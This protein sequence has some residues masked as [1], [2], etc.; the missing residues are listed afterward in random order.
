[1]NVEPSNGSAATEVMIHTADAARVENDGAAIPSSAFAVFPSDIQIQLL[2]SPAQT[3]AN[4][5][6]NIPA[7]VMAAP[8]I[9]MAI[10]MCD[11]ALSDPTSGNDIIRCINAATHTTT[12]PAREMPLCK[13]QPMMANTIANNPQA[14]ST[15]MP[16]IC[17]G[18]ATA[19]KATAQ[20]R[21]A[22]V[23]ALVSG[24]S[25]V[26]NTNPITTLNMP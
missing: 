4:P 23:N 12:D 11:S 18:T 2:Q 7:D 14:T 21:Y 17:T 19:N 15:D 22:T 25:F 16:R 24:R 6:A 3:A 20:A 26:G 1:M 10:F 9:V 8:S 13:Y 5:Q